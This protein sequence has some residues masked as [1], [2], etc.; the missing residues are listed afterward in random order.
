M[1]RILYCLMGISLFFVACEKENSPSPSLEDRNW[2][3]IKD[4]PSN[5]LDHLI[6]RVYENTGISIF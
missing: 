5:P 3:V 4:N 6:Y 1:K 2:F